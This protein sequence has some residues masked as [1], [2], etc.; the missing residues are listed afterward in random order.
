EQTEYQIQLLEN[1]HPGETLAV[2][3]TAMHL[4][5]SILS[6]MANGNAVTIIPIHAE[7]S[8]QQAADLLNVSRPFL[9]KLLEDGKIPY[10]KVGTHR[11]IKVNDLL[12]YKNKIDTRRREALDELAEQAQQLDMGY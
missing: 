12:R 10:R 9:V 7:L 4:L 2:P 1:D 8:T 6:E 11:R 5:V 3:A